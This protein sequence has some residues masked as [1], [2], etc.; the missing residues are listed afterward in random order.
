MRPEPSGESSIGLIS[1]RWRAA[2]Y[3]ALL[4]SLSSFVHAQDKTLD[5]KT[6]TQF[7]WG[8]DLMG[9]G[10]GIIAEY[11]RFNYKPQGGMFYFT[12]YGRAWRDYTESE[13]RDNG[14]LGKLYYL[15]MNYSPFENTSLRLGRQYVN[16]TAGSAI[17]DGIRLDLSG[18]GP[19]GISFAEGAD[20]RF[21]LDG[22]QSRI[23]NHFVGLN[24]RLENVRATQLGVSYVQ[25]YDDWDTAREEFGLNFRRSWNYFSPYGEIRYDQLSADFSEA[26]LGLDLFPVTNLMLKGEF[27]Q[28]YPTFD[29]TSIYSVFAVDQYREYLVQAD[30]SLNAPLALL[31]SYTRQIYGDSDRANVYTAGAN[32]YPGDHLT[33]KVSVDRRTGYGGHDWGFETDG[34]YKIRDRLTLSAGAQYDTYKRPDDFSEN[35][36]TRYWVGGRWNLRTAASITVRLEDDINENFNHLPLGRITLDWVF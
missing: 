16:F 11:A 24:V 1:H 14:P 33:L 2:I 15:Y 19:I 13:I 4:L 7:L 5:V 23:G 26:L 9:E 28:S 32:I 31:A 22:T 35:Y 25:R 29:S 10:Q 18:L 8:D 20:V 17:L 12:G 3:I 34:D 6:S 36:A 30:Y 21:S 27:Y